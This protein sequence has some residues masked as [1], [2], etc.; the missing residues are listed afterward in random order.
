MLDQL[1]GGRTR[2][3]P[4]TSILHPDRRGVLRLLL[5]VGLAPFVP[6]HWSA[7]STN[8]FAVDAAAAATDWASGGT[9]A[10]TAK[11]TYPDPFTDV[12]EL[13]EL[14]ASTTQGP[15]TTEDDLVREDVSEGW[16]GLPVR[17]ALRVVD[18]NCAPVSG[19]TVKIWHTNL[20]GSY[21]GQTPNNGMCLQQ[22]S[23]ASADFFRVNVWRFLLAL[24][25]G[26]CIRYGLE[27]GLA[28]R[29]GEHAADLFKQHYPKIGLA[30]AVLI[31]AILI[32]KTLR[33]RK[34][35]DEGDESELPNVA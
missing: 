25:I 28:V 20:E 5:G 12:P 35:G 6:R 9:A 21:S 27:G 13:C 2:K 29:Y 22:Q 4:S 19:A 31:I 7:S 24:G 1:A 33:N 14:V 23:Y 32:V 17:L 11:A 30:L 15:C 26:R 10:M 16:S 18:S 3:E 8:A 34:N